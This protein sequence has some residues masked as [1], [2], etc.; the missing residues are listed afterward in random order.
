MFPSRQVYE[1]IKAK[2][3]V[4]GRTKSWES[5]GVVITQCYAEA[6][7][8]QN[9]VPMYLYKYL[10]VYMYV[11]VFLGMRSIQVPAYQSFLKPR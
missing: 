2:V 10:Y 1:K 5:F 6:I 4:N 9:I 11:Y 8:V 3:R 7:F